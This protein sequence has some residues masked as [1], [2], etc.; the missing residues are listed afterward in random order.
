LLVTLSDEELVEVRRRAALECRT[1]SAM[2]RQLIRE[3]LAVWWASEGRLP[4]SVPQVG[5]VVDP[6]SGSADGAG[7][8]SRLG[9]EFVPQPGNALKC[10]CGRRKGDH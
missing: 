6:A 3:S 4:A 5:P 9:H 10:T 1:V 7:R 2:G 8:P